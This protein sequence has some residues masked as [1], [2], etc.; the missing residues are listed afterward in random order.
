MCLDVWCAPKTAAAAAAALAISLAPWPLAGATAADG[1]GATSST[2]LAPAPA[3]SRVRPASPLL[4]TPPPD[5]VA[6]RVP[7]DYQ[8]QR[9]TDGS[10]DLV[11]EAPGFSARVAHD[12][13][14]RFR[15]RHVSALKLIPIV[16]GAPPAGVP[17]LEGTLRGLGKKRGA[18]PPGPP[19]DPT[20]DE[21]RDPATTFSRFHP[22][23]REACQYP[24]PCFFDASVL[25][26]GA[27]GK[28]DVTD[29]LMRMAGQDP[30]RYEKA[31]FLTATREMRVRL[32][33]RAHAED[34]ARSGEELKHRLQTIACDDQLRP[35]ERRAIVDAL[36]AELDTGTPEGRAQADE[37]RR[38]LGVLDH[39]DGG[40]RCP[41]R[42]PSP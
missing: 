19:P 20:P 8:L 42:A 6:P 29:E 36:R 16:P 32:A 17:T 11:Y 35:S 26:V 3:A 18:R 41:V 30:Y 24:R 33:A 1:G 22:D 34:V 9:A 28:L 2:T 38:F 5:G 27:R 15:D 4:L 37:I 7:D 12:G 25:L 10:G 14:V 40:V 13:T 23:P 21:T 39:Q 31:R